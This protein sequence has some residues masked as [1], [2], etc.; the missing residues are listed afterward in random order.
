VGTGTI[1]RGFG[2]APG[3]GGPAGDVTV[4]DDAPAGGA[5]PAAGS[6]D[7]FGRAEAAAWAA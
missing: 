4:D 2:E 5:V 3:V 1:V 7:G 6:A